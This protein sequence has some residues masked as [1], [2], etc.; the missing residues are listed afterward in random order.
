MKMLDKIAEMIGIK[1]KAEKLY[2]VLNAAKH[3]SYAFRIEDLGEGM[4]LID[5]SLY[6]Y[7]KP[8]FLLDDNAKCA[9]EFMDDCET[10]MT[11]TA[12]DI[13]WESLKTLENK[14]VSRAQRLSFHFPSF[15]LNY[16]NGVAEVMWQLNPDG[17]YYMDEDGYGMTDDVEV[18]IYGFIDRKGKVLVKFSYIGKDWDQ[19]KKMRKEAEEIVKDN[20]R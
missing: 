3:D 6:G 1:S 4:R 13:D 9:Y 11:V 7:W 16:E 19:L 15:V 5:E 2:E 12:D 14:C 17:M 10:L 8:R 20:N 18:T